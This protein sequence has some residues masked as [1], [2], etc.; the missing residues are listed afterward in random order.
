[1]KQFAANVGDRLICQHC[2]KTKA[3]AI[4]D[5]FS[6]ENLHISQL[7]FYGTIPDPDDGLMCDHCCSE[8]I[9]WERDLE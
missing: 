8:D 2:G 1:M 3:T 5:I 6:Y 4:R 7:T 9:R